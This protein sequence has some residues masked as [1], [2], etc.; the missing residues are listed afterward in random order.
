M[1]YD[2][3]RDSENNNHTELE[4]ISWLVNQSLDQRKLQL[5]PDLALRFVSLRDIS[6]NINRAVVVVAKS[7]KDCIIAIVVVV[8]V[9]VQRESIEGCRHNYGYNFVSK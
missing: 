6:R 4:S 2:A 7:P 8:V 5:M 9:V 3:L 1:E